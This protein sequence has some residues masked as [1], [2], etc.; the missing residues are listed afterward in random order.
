MDKEFSN[1]EICNCIQ[2]YF[3]MQG[4]WRYKINIIIDAN[5]INRNLIKKISV[6]YT[7]NRTVIQIKT[8]KEEGGKA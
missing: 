5:Q 4:D 7:K 3:E 2:Y 6:E 8:I 1:K